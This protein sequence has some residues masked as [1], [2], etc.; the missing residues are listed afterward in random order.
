[1]NT[2]VYVIIGILIILPLIFKV[3]R[4]YERA[5]V[6]TLGRFTSVKGPGL[7]IMILSMTLYPIFVISSRDSWKLSFLPKFCIWLI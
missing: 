3:L 7:I 5:V 6:F 4:E 1:M 2:L